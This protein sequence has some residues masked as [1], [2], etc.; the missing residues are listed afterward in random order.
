MTAHL[1]APPWGLPDDQDVALAHA[2]E[3]E[4]WATALLL[5]RDHLPTEPAPPP[6]LLALQAFLRFQDAL[7]VMQEELVPASQEALA[8]L[9]RAAEAGLP[10][11]DVAPLREEVERAL[12]AETA[13]ELRAEALTPEAARAAPLE[14]V[15]DAA[16]RLRPSRP[17]HAAALF[18]V[19][20]GRDAAH[21]PLHRADAG[22]AL[23]L[24]GER[25][26]A[27]PLL[28]EALAADWRS[29][30]LRPGRLR[31]DWAASLLIEDALAAG[32]GERVAR[33]WAEA[34]ARGAQLGLPFPANWLNQERL[35]QRL[36]ARGDGLRAAQVA[37]RIEA[38]R[39]YVP[40]AL[41]QKLREARGL[42]RAQAE[43]GGKV[44]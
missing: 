27:R 44:H 9:E 11:D 14:Q 37:T 7:T 8:L 40:R 4:D 25:D 34:Q 22:V 20:A 5:L 28:E 30:A 24:A 17:A 36:L 2:L 18:L 23:H 19:A 26:Q 35:L 15:V 3:R 1:F 33:L 31:T 29:P 12:A 6:R 42:A 41:A 39:E 16:E 10:M 13:A 43:G 38:G 32:D 21:A